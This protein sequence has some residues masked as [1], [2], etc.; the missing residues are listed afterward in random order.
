MRIEAGPHRVVFRVIPKPQYTQRT[1]IVSDRSDRRSRLT[2]VD[3]TCGAMVVV[4]GLQQLWSNAKSN[5]RGL[6][7]YLNTF[8]L[9]KP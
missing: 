9:I 7:I 8:Y 2:T 1:M 4:L 6:I 5:R 3:D